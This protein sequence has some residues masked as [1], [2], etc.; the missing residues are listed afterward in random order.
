MSV[1]AVVRHR[2]KD[3]TS[4]RAFYDGFAAVQEDG[5]VEHQSVHQ[6]VADPNEVLITHQF[7]TQA[8]AEAFLNGSELREAMQSAGVAAP[9]RV[10]LYHD[11]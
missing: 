7:E 11:V 1:T 5:G 8:A 3:Y 6:D 10:E 4:W 9:P 2:V